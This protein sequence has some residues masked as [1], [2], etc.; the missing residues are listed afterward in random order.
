MNI[1]TTNGL[2]GRYMAEC[3]GA[4]VVLR[5]VQIRLGVPSYPGDELVLTPLGSFRIFPPPL[6]LKQLIKLG[7]Q[8][9]L[10]GGEVPIEDSKGNNQGAGGA[11]QTGQGC[12]SPAIQC[13]RHLIEAGKA[14]S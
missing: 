1:L 4:G 14:V 2:V 7:R 12:Q 11:G 10:F 3:F 6:G 8:S 9:R 13:M 5:S